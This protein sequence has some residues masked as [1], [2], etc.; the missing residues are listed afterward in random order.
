MDE[1][2]ASLDEEDEGAMSNDNSDIV[3][4]GKGK[5]KKQRLRK[6]CEACRG[7]KGKCCPS[8]TGGEKCER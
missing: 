3:G 4:G 1:R 7:S 8:S 6:S 5:N 2:E